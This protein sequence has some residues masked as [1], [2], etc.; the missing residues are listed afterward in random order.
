VLLC[1]AH[2]EA[3]E[4]LAAQGARVHAME[5][6]RRQYVMATPPQPVDPPMQS[7][8]IRRRPKPTRMKQR[9]AG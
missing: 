2:Q 7:S 8:N 4:R 3:V 5:A 1:T 6:L 9:E